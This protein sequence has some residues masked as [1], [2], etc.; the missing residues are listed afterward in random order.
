MC[1]A[2]DKQLS[3]AK[4]RCRLFKKGKFELKSIAK[5]KKQKEWYWDLPN[6]VTLHERAEEAQEG[7]GTQEAQATEE[8]QQ[9]EEETQEA[10]EGETL[11]EVT[12]DEL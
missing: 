11:G 10:Q 6:D 1:G 8:A 12:S 7:R 2:G 5:G 3:I 9:P 4:R